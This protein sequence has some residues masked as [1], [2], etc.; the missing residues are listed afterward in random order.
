MVP[1]KKEGKEISSF[2]GAPKI[3]LEETE[4]FYLEVSIKK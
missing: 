1:L 4:F 3:F 2:S